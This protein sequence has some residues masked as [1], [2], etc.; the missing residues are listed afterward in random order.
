MLN[1]RQPLRYA[2][3]TAVKTCCKKTQQII[4]YP[5]PVRYRSRPPTAVNTKRLALR[6]SF[7]FCI[8]H[9]P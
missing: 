3:K 7:P 6:C 8:A 9:F 4:L 1:A 5:K 2:S